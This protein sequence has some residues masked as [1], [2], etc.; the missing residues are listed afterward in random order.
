[1]KYFFSFIVVVLAIVVY[2]FL[3]GQVGAV[4]SAPL[5]YVSAEILPLSNNVSV[6]DN[7]VSESTQI[8][9]GDKIA[10][11]ETG[12][13]IV[14]SGPQLITA[15]NENTTVTFNANNELKETK[16]EVVAGK[17]FSRLERALEQDEVYEVYT[18]TLAAAVRGTMFAT[19][20]G[21]QADRIVVVEGEVLV[22]RR[23]GGNTVTVSVGNQVEMIDNNLVVTPISAV[24]YPNWF[25]E[26]VDPNWQYGGSPEV[27]LVTANR[28]GF[29]WGNTG[30]ITIVGTGFN[31]VREVE[32]DEELI[33]FVPVSDTL[34]RVPVGEFSKAREDSEV[35]L[36]LES[37]SVSARDVFVG[38]EAEVRANL[39][40]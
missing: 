6:A 17:L 2:Y 10:T 7:F 28:D 15:I 30:L 34:V 39:F 12:R 38:S 23:E 35:I 9:D 3:I 14:K 1:M 22:S 19:E 11:N 18:P 4:T 13:A 24:D 20:V 5:R 29:W 16:F 33:S 32:L 40:W 37:D 25:K 21:D 27:T 26:Y 31:Q 8:S 36:R